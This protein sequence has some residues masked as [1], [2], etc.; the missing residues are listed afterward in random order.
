M[1]AKENPNR[2]KKDIAM[3]VKSMTRKGKNTEEKNKKRKTG[4]RK[5]KLNSVKWRSQQLRIQPFTP[6]WRFHKN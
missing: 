3:I 1:F 5:P 4:N 2:K 6:F